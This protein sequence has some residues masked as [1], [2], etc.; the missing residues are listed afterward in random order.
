MTRAFGIPATR[1]FERAGRIAAGV[2]DLGFSTIWS[3][4]TP[5]ADGIVTAANMAEATESIRVAVGVVAVDRRPPAEIVRA[6]RDLEIPLDRFL[7]GVGAGSS[8]DPLRLVRG[9]VSELRDSLGPEA[10]IGLAAMGPRMCRLAGEIAD[11]VL[12]N[13]MLPERITWARQRV[14]E[15]ADRS[16]REDLPEMAAYV[17]AAVGEGAGERIAT[18]AAKYNGYPAYTRH[19]KAMGAPV[20]SVGVIDAGAGYLADLADYDKVL[21]EVVVRALPAS[22]SIASTLAVAEASRPR[23][24]K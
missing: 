18:E 14:A 22:D 6:V 3:N 20:A 23:G 1:D 11:T 7:L 4:D 8:R 15:G 9:A 24:G 12:F 13:W 17:R 10:R 19:F 2:E 21:D 16:G 5:A